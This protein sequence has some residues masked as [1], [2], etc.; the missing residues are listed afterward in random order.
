MTKILL[1]GHTGKMGLALYKVLQKEYDVI[2]KNSLDFDATNFVQVE[3]M[4]VEVQPDIVI[5]T[6]AFHGIDSC[7]KEPERALTINTLFVKLLSELSNKMNFLLVHFST[8]AVFN[9]QKN[10]TYVESNTPKPINIYGLTKYGADC[11]IQAIS[12][13]YYIIRYS[14]LFGENPRNNQLIEKTLYKIKA[15]EEIRMADDVVCSPSYSLDIAKEVKRILNSSL[16][17]GI[18]HV[19]N[20]GKA[21]LYE[22]IVEAAKLLNISPNIKKAS[23]LDFGHLALKNTDTL[24]TSEKI[25]TLRPWQDALK[26]YL[27]NF[28]KEMQVIGEESISK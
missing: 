6:V 1:L 16:P 5:N 24:L 22:I 10:F 17:Y 4:V 12:N 2:C 15:G 9:N 20:R 18:Y 27:E 23:H 21:T 3:E 13:K 19:V 26:D 11:F 8:D 7:E 14:L 25:N 28:K